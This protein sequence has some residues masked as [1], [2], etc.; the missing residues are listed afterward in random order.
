MILVIVLTC[1]HVC[2]I[3]IVKSYDV[4]VLYYIY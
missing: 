3:F 1:D 4:F 2:E